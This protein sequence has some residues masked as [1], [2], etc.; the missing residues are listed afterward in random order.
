MDLAQY[1][2]YKSFKCPR[3]GFYVS[4]KALGGGAPFKD[5][6]SGKYVLTVVFWCPQCDKNFFAEVFVEA[7]NEEEALKYYSPEKLAKSVAKVYPKRDI[8]SCPAV[9]EKID[10]LFRHVQA[11]MTEPEWHPAL[12]IV[13]CRSVLEAAV[14]ELGAEGN[15]LFEKIEFLH[16]EGI[17]PRAITEWCHVIRKFGNK[18]AHEIE[19]TREEAE[20][21]V[22]LTKFFLIYAFEL[23]ARVEE[24]R[25]RYHG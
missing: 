2:I 11:P 13:G 8:Y 1:G 9:P 6:I 17:L 14:S 10:T 18:A 15:N 16:K 5:E 4:A 25:K 19:A 21:I 7:P 20:E 3:C 23:P 12:V 24:I 22:E